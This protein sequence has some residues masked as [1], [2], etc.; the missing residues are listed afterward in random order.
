[1]SATIDCELFR[2]YYA[3]HGDI[4]G[5][6]KSKKNPNALR[7]VPVYN[8]EN[9]PFNVQE[10]YWEDL[11]DTN[12][13]LST[14]LTRNYNE[15]YERNKSYQSGDRNEYSLFQR[16]HAYNYNRSNELASSRLTAKS[17]PSISQFNHHMQNLVFD[18]NE[19]DMKEETM[20]M[21]ITLLKY[22]DEQDLKVIR[23]NGG[24]DLDE[25]KSDLNDT[26]D[27]SFADESNHSTR[28]TR[29]RIIDGLPEVRGSVLIFVPGMQQ[30][31]ELSDLIKRE[32]AD[33]KLNVLP[34]HSDIILE[35]QVRV[36]EKPD[37]TWR[38]VIISTSIAESSI[39]VS[40]IKY[41]IDFCLTKE[42]Y[43]DPYTSYTH[44][45][46]EWASKSSLNQRRGRAGRVSDGTCYRL[47]TRAF[48]QDLD[49]HA[50]VNKSF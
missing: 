34:L 37:P 24:A 9:T 29:P 6:E 5:S 15:K 33:K 25:T 21:V 17:G 30:I 46:L 49:E 16:N 28:S 4:Y 44:L 23:E 35:Q 13:F 10:F 12:S 43:C 36:F 19:P 26:I 50:K 11:V 8:I 22:F 18:Y 48:H 27:S 40:D 2:K 38:K 7:L 1:M 31:Q 47:I 20:S 42:L 41:V 14:T 32:L 45:R 3:L 39:T